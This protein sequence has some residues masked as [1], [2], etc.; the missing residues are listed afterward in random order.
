M[1]DKCIKEYDEFEENLKKQI[2]NKVAKSI[3]L[4]YY[5]ID[6]SY[7]KEL[8]KY[9]DNLRRNKNSKQNFT[10]SPKIFNNFES[11]MKHLEENSKLSIIS[12]NLISKIHPKYDLSKYTTVIILG[13]NGNLIIYFDDKN[14]FLLFKNKNSNKLELNK[15]NLYIIHE[16][17]KQ[18]N[19][20]YTA[21]CNQK[22]DYNKIN[23][24]YDYISSFK[25]FIN[26]GNKAEPKYEKPN[27]SKHISQE[28]KSYSSKYKAPLIT[29]I[30]PKTEQSYHPFSSVGKRRSNYEESKINNYNQYDSNKAVER[31]IKNNNTNEFHKKLSYNITED[32]NKL[33]DE[34]KGYENKKK[35]NVLKIQMLEYE[36]RL[37]DD[38][39]RKVK[40]KLKQFNPYYKRMSSSILSG[41][42]NDKIKSRD[43]TELTYTSGKYNSSIQNRNE[44]IGKKVNAFSRRRDE[45]KKENNNQQKTNDYNNC[46]IMKKKSDDNFTQ[47]II[48]RA[49]KRKKM[50]SKSKKIPNKISIKSFQ[51]PKLVKLEYVKIKLPN[52]INSIIYCLSQI[53][54]LT[55]YFFTENCEKNIL[56]NEQSELSL[57]YHYL[58]HGLWPINNN[59]NKFWP[60]TFM[61]EMNKISKEYGLP[62]ESNDPNDIHYFIVFILEQLHRELKNKINIK[63]RVQYDQYD[64]NNIIKYIDDFKEE[65]SIISKLFFGYKETT[66]E[67]LNCNNNANLENKIL[68]Y[69]YE[70]FNCLV[71]PLDEIKQEINSNNVRIVDCFNYIQKTQLFTGD[72]RNYCNKCEQVYDSNFTTTIYEFP[73][74]LILVF[75]RNKESGNN[76]KLDFE[77]KINTRDLNSGAEVNTGIVFKRQIYDLCGVIS[78]KEGTFIDYI[79]SCRSP[80]DKS[81]YRYTSSEIT[82]IGNVQNDIINYETPYVLFYKKG[83]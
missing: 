29:R 3:Y 43:S 32:K 47:L 17:S 72:K 34:L 28:G 13:G 16:D 83:K 52:Y 35:Q 42:E 39:I 66:E 67:C 64:Q 26:D 8:G 21:I 40:E 63:K 37:L 48:S 56:D 54:D 20:S 46:E 5:L 38:N 50:K 77:E 36:N 10:S 51:N 60:N 62:Y 79:A 65:S 53:E 14:A 81:W 7:M 73:E 4:S 61:I 9:I 33:L 69:N 70:M 11:A 45:T 44:S 49:D 75:V 71:F 12:K 80:V 82:P 25:D 31:I 76:V 23:K 74:V 59:E 24:N 27:L 19:H 68:C 41:D 1:N 78:Y 57:E 15:N 30:N 18:K 22:I 58:I 2:D 6:E 55:N